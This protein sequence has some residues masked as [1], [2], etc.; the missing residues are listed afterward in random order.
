MPR[1]RQHL[2][3]ASFSSAVHTGRHVGH[4][5]GH[6]RHA[7]R[8]VQ[9][10]S[11]G[12]RW[13]HRALLRR[14]WVLHASAVHH[15]L[16]G[17]CRGGETTCLVWLLVGFPQYTRQRAVS[18]RTHK[19]SLPVQMRCLTVQQT[20]RLADRLLMQVRKAFGMD[21][22]TITELAE[23]EP[24]GCEGVN[25]LPY[26]TGRP[27]PP[28]VRVR[29]VAHLSPGDVGST[30]SPCC[31]KPCPVSSKAGQH[32]LC[33]WQPATIGDYRAGERT[34]NWPGSSGVLT[35]LRPGQM[36]PGLLY[37]AALEGATYSLLNGASCCSCSLMPAAGQYTGLKVGLARLM[38]REPEP[39]LQ[40]QG[41]DAGS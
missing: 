1:C 17:R 24:P 27:P 2:Q 40:S 16:H 9:P 23:K 10:G 26:L 5:A 18:A 41:S 33:I 11:G 7:L 15:E 22:G 6:L 29:A 12:S 35:G 19:A 34:P 13:R 37:R 30:A 31:C 36:R 28:S 3:A 21:H 32:C 20:A 25:F 14:H 38:C 39:E 8:R 4:L